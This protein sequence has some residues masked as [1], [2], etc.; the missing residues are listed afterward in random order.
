MPQDLPASP[1]RDAIR[2]QAQKA[3]VAI[4]ADKAT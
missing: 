2:W 1:S 3:G 4:V